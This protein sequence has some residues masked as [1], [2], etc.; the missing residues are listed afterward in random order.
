MQ[1]L[2]GLFGAG[3]RLETNKRA[4]ADPGSPARLSQLDTKRDIMDSNR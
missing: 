3:F 2:E 1:L 4:I